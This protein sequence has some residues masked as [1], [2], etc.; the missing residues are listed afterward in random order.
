[1]KVALRL[2]GSC[3]LNKKFY[4]WYSI[5]HYVIWNTVDKQIHCSNK[6]MII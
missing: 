2:V 4:V 3:Y 6:F 5:K 1:M